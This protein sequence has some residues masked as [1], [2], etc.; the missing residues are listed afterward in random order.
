[1][2]NN[3]SDVAWGDT[4]SNAD[5]NVKKQING[6]VQNARSIQGALSFHFYQL[7]YIHDTDGALNLVVKNPS[8]ASIINLH[9]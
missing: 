3:D 1:M 7:L 9:L 8:K 2:V 5:D 4:D 6:V